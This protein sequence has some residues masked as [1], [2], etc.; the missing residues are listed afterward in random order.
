V[1]GGSIL[2]VH[3]LV[4][5]FGINPVLSTS[6]S[7]FVVGSTSLV[8]AINNYTK[9]LVRINVALLFGKS[10]VTTVFVT[11]KFIIPYIPENLFTVGNYTITH[12]LFTMVLFAVLMIMAAVALAMINSKAEKE[13][14]TA[15]DKKPNLLKLLLNGIAIGMT[16]GLLGA[17]G[18][19]L[20]M[21]TLVLFIGL[22]MKET[23]GT[24]L[25][26]IALNSLVG[27]SGDLGYFK[28]EW[29]F[30]LE[31]TTIAIS[32]IFIGGIVNKKVS[33]SKLKPGFGWF[34]LFMGNYIAVTT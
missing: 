3:V 4:Y 24:S 15:S 7:L 9:N 21:P 1:A 26:I 27:F 23:V 8:G 17:G 30:L 32:G 12:L 33:N 31:I 13:N 25:L 19:F 10:S 29:F 16:T 14:G 2:T 18:G 34:I 11:R 6:Y 5:L 22:P 28:I 20:L